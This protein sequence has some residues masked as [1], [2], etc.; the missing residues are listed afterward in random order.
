MKKLSGQ[1]FILLLDQFDQILGNPM[2][3]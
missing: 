3:F 2:T 1:I